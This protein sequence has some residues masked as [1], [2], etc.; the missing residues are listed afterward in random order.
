MNSSLFVV[1]KR[2]GKIRPLAAE[3]N[4]M[5]HTIFYS[6]NSAHHSGVIPMAAYLIVDIDLSDRSKSRAYTGKVQRTVEAYG[7]RYLCKWGAAEAFEGEWNVNRNCWLSLHL[8]TMPGNGGP[9]GLG[10]QNR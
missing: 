1:E 8:Q 7:G 6:V 4:P 10:R 9:S 2:S 3:I 5:A